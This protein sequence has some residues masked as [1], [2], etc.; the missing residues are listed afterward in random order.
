MV[1]S[2]LVATSGEHAYVVWPVVELCRKV[3]CC[4]L[5]RSGV[6]SGH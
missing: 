4:T 3:S 1:E 2:C 5:S 6:A